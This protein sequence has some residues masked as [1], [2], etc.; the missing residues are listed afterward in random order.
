MAKANTKLSNRKAGKRKPLP[1]CEVC[2][3]LSDR[4]EIIAGQI[5][6]CHNTI[7]CFELIVEEL[8]RLCCGQNRE[9]IGEVFEKFFLQL[10]IESCKIPKELRLPAAMERE[11]F[12]FLRKLKP[13]DDT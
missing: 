10:H 11:L 13:Q 9:E 2:R 6:W 3:E 1:V 12:E 8:T 4:D 5:V 7:G